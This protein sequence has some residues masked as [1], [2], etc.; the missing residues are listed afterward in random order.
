MCNWRGRGRAWGL[1]GAEGGTVPVKV[2]EVAQDDHKRRLVERLAQQPL[3]YRRLGLALIACGGVGRE[4][5]E[6]QTD[7]RE[8][9]DLAC[10]GLRRG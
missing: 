10:E 3:H 7:Q 9:V 4:R 8:R 2:V 6:V 5:L 1:F